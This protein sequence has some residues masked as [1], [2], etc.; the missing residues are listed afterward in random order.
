MNSSS[1]GLS[2]PTRGNPPMIC[3]PTLTSR[4]IPAH[5]GE[6]CVQSLD[7]RTLTVYPRPRGGTLLTAKRRVRRSGLSPPTRGNPRRASPDERP[8]GSIPAH[9]GEPA[10]CWVFP[11]KARV[12]PRPRG[13]TAATAWT[14]YR[15]QGLSPP[16]RGNRLSGGGA[17]GD[18]GSIPAHAGE[19]SHSR[20]L[21]G[22]AGVYP[23]PRGGTCEGE[24]WTWI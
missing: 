13:G 7:H 3:P 19:P 16:T 10:I 6:P 24:A 23:R 1:S 8:A 14:G 5:A 11:T 17:S 12:Y 4:S 2:P 22:V 9:A 20:R 18:V 21:R 15:K